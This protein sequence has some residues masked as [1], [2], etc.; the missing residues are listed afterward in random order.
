MKREFSLILC[1]SLLSLGCCLSGLVC[2][3]SVFFFFLLQSQITNSVIKTKND[4]SLIS[5]ENI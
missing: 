5:K 2:F 1:S 3:S 4:H